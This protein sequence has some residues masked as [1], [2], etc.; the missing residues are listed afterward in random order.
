MKSLV[1]AFSIITSLLLSFPIAA[2]TPDNSPHSLAPKNPYDIAAPNN[3]APTPQITVDAAP[4]YASQWSLPPDSVLAEAFNATPPKR[5]S[6]ASMLA[7][8]PAELALIDKWIQ[9]IDIDHPQIPV[10]KQILLA[11]PLPV[12]G[13]RLVELAK[14]SRSSALQNDWKLW[15][16]SYP[17]AYISVLRAWLKL[18]PHD[19]SQFLRLLDEYAKYNSENALDVWAQLISN[20]SAR[21][22]GKLAA[23]GLD[24]PHCQPS[25]VR[26]IL[27]VWTQ[28]KQDNP[29]ASPDNPA[30]LR[31]IRAYALCQSSNNL[32]DTSQTCS[33][34]R[35]FFSHSNYFDSS[36]NSDQINALSNLIDM[37][38]SA[39]LSRR[40]AAIDFCKGWPLKQKQILAL[41]ESSKNTTEKAHA[42]RILHDFCDENQHDRI[43]DALNHGDETLRLE[44]ASIIADYPQDSP[45]LKILTNAFDKEIWPET[46][47][48]LYHAVVSQ[49]Q[50]G[51][52]VRS[53]Q[54]QL[55]LDHTRSESIRLAAFHDLA[56]SDVNAVDLD[57]M[58][59]LIKSDSPIELIAVVSEFL[60][61]NQ[62]QTRPTLRTWI[63]AQQPFNRRFFST[64]ARFVNIDSS[65]QDPSALELMRNVCTNADEQEN[66]L[67]P[68]LNYMTDNAQSEQDRELLHKLQQRK[69][70]VDAM[71]NLEFAL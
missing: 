19:S 43:L 32:A 35:D 7:E 59:E 6:F 15:L 56:Q 33:Q 23:F 18:V 68:C 63:Q 1:S 44:A 4:Q 14:K 64:F 39:S 25:I 9:N 40:I 45:N 13:P 30:I 47:L 52:D 34:R 61:A 21:D 10:L 67:L 16:Q 3:P 71:V 60:Y 58:S 8:S 62:P 2:Q 51:N 38:L 42:L 37:L 22:L 54:K 12:A 5:T 65:D 29:D 17:D 55:F 28:I 69:N 24:N 48:K 11:M 46:Q 53:F 66:L 41:Y 57:D 70:Q 31:L 49:S 27:S 50:S 26:R 36:I 20:F